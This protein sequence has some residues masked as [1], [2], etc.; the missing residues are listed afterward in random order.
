MRAYFLF[1]Y[2]L[3][4][5]HFVFFFTF[6]FFSSTSP[7]SICCLS[8]LGH[9]HRFLEGMTKETKNAFF[10]MKFDGNSSLTKVPCV[11]INID[12]GPCCWRW[13]S[14]SAKKRK[15]KKNPK[16]NT[17][18]ATYEDTD[19]LDKRTHSRSSHTLARASDKT[20]ESRI[21]LGNKT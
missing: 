18:L 12:V 3:S 15:S 13:K 7:S 14:N 4:R 10:S 17:P 6:Q 19:E 11:W 5:V 16:W 2:Y 21:H 20:L 9:M 8:S 1:F